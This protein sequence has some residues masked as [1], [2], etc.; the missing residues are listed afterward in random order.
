MEG[1]RG[2]TKA[3]S[4][5]GS[6]DEGAGRRRYDLTPPGCAVREEAGERDQGA[7]LQGAQV[8]APPRDE[9]GKS[10]ASSSPPERSPASGCS[11]WPA[12]A[13]LFCSAFGLTGSV[14]TE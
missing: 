4:E 1:R 5:E 14:H 7:L 6:Q 10:P 12:G 9:R 8:E 11:S 2:A 3:R 13:W